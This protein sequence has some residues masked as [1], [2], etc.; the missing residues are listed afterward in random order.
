MSSADS[1]IKDTS[2]ES[3][4]KAKK[5]KKIKHDENGNPI[6]KIKLDENGNPIKKKKKPTQDD[7]GGTPASKS[8][9]RRSSTAPQDEVGAMT[10]NNSSRRRSSATV[11]DGL[12]GTANSQP[13]RRR[14]SAVARSSSTKKMQD[15]NLSSPIP[16]DEEPAARNRSLRKENSAGMVQLKPPG[17]RT[18]DPVPKSGYAMR[19]GSITANVPNLGAL[20][21]AEALSD[22]VMEPDMS[23]EDEPVQRITMANTMESLVKRE[24][25]P[26][27]S[28]NGGGRQL[29]ASRDGSIASLQS[30]GSDRNKGAAVTGPG[31]ELITTAVPAGKGSR[32]NMARASESYDIALRPGAVSV[33]TAASAGEGSGPSLARGSDPYGEAAGRVGA[34]AVASAAPAGK[35]SGPSMARGSDNYGEAAG[36]VGAVSVASAAPAGK[37]SGPSLSRGSDYYGGASSRVGAVSVA[38]AA[39]EGKARRQSGGYAAAAGVGAVTVATAAPAGKVGASGPSVAVTSESYGERSRL[40]AVSVSTVAPSGKGDR[41]RFR[42]PPVGGSETPTQ[43]DRPRIGAM[44][45]NTPVPQGKE[46]ATAVFSAPYESPN[47]ERGSLRTPNVAR[48]NEKYRTSHF[49]P[50]NTPGVQ[51]AGPSHFP[52]NAETYEEAMRNEKTRIA[53]FP[54]AE[55][56]ARDLNESLSH[57]AARRKMDEYSGNGTGNRRGSAHTIQSETDQSTAKSAP[58]GD[59]PAYANSAESYDGDSLRSGSLSR[60]SYR[61]VRSEAFTPGEEGFEA[62]VHPAGVGDYGN[63]MPL[64]AEPGVAFVGTEDLKEAS[65]YCSFW[66]KMLVIALV[67]GGAGAGVAI[68]LTGGGSKGPGVTVAPSNP[69]VDGFRQAEIRFACIDITEESV[70]DDISTPQHAAYQWLVQD[71]TL[72]PISLSGLTKEE[73]DKI[74][75]RYSLATLYY[76][77]AGAKWFSAEKWLDPVTEECLWQHIT[78]VNSNRDV[79]SI[80]TGERNNLAGSIPSELHALLSLRE[81]NFTNNE[82]TAIT[83]DIGLLSNLVNLDLSANRIAGKI[84]SSLFSLS[85]LSVLNLG[86]NKFTGTLSPLVGGLSSLGQLHV[87]DNLLTGKLT[88]ELQKMSRLDVLDVNLNK[89]SG[90]LNQILSGLTGLKVI[91]MSENQFTGSLSGS[92]LVQFQELIE[93]DLAR[94]DLLGSTIP[95]EIGAVTTLGTFLYSSFYKCSKLGC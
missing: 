13:L 1:S 67:L 91:A 87:F 53:H 95:T 93:L 60:E 46:S 7:E 30:H 9:R 11:H 73:W 35:G 92:F 33:A 36:R 17:M 44:T 16:A 28:L 15:E 90:S 82:L 12:D 39:P 63:D 94:L 22:E 42:A 89:M 57:V 78:C 51:T 52:S 66:F 6:K 21:A 64:E 4:K 3:R 79:V 10:T 24:K 8:S 48:P 26:R 34:V 84:P 45:M 86:A 49:P 37:A 71:D 20:M 68:A 59:G 74:L 55:T 77:T 65:W 27:V 23:G 47:K 88:T 29:A 80:S 62:E 69:P 19:R 56:Y 43:S 72:S 50:A 58:M 25:A 81:L 41:S 5:E 76:A 85:I 14:S 2:G 38:S 18:E 70:I 32:S 31:A 54:S 75:V 83:P 40:G 61:G